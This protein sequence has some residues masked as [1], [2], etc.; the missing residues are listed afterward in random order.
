MKRVLSTLLFMFAWLALPAQDI[1][2]N[3][4][5]VYEKRL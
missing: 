5:G 4:N 3:E 1:T 2:L